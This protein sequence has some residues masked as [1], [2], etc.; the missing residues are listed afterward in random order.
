MP[1]KDLNAVF[2][3]VY[4]AETAHKSVAPTKY[5]QIP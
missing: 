2:T 3:F 5:R 1:S 4:A